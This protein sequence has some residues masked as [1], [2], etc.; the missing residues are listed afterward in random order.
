MSAAAP[1]G[2]VHFRGAL[3]LGLDWRKTPFKNYAAL[4]FYDS[5]G[6]FPQLE[7][8]RRSEYV[9]R[10][11]M[12][13]WEIH[14]YARSNFIKDVVDFLTPLNAK[15]NIIRELVDKRRIEIHRII[16]DKVCIL[17]VLRNWANNLHDVE[18]AHIARALDK[19][20]R[21]LRPNFER[22]WKYIVAPSFER[23][24]TKLPRFHRI[25]LY[26]C[27]PYILPKSLTRWLAEKT[28]VDYSYAFPSREWWPS[29]LTELFRATLSRLLGL[30][31]CT[32]TPA[33]TQ[34]SSTPASALGK[35]HTLH[36]DPITSQTPPEASRSPVSDRGPPSPCARTPPAPLPMKK[37]ENGAA[38]APFPLSSPVPVSTPNM[39]HPS[40]P[41]F[42]LIPDTSH[43]PIL[44]PTT[45]PLTNPPHSTSERLRR[46]RKSVV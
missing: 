15:H 38:S 30:R 39:S 28:S 29:G 42:P 18:I 31:A 19:A 34:G 41:F 21:R 1:I 23:G 9:H 13:R 43:K 12:A 3:R 17:L 10:I 14:N 36:I 45:Q 25:Q 35:I 6:T 40:N 7:I 46:D 32:P 20:A 2:L 26:D 37:E 16:H 11:R 27:L 22:I 5:S 44:P 24:Q 8:H 33:L 4:R